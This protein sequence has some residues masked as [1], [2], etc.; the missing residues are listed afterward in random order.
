[1]TESPFGPPGST[2]GQTGSIADTHVYATFGT[3]TVTVTV[4]DNGGLSSTQTFQIV[5]GNVGPTV[6]PIAQQS[7]D[8]G[9]QFSLPGVTFNDP[10]TLD[11]H[12]ATVNWGDGSSTEVA[13]VTESPFGPPGSTSGLT[14]AIS[15]SHT[16]GEPGT[17]T[18]TISVTDNG[19]LTD[20]RTFTL[21]VNDVPPS[22]TTTIATGSLNEGSVLTTSTIGFS[23]PTF[24]VPALNY[25]PTFTYSIN[26]GDGSAVQTGSAPVTQAGSV[27]VATQGSF[28]LTHL[29]GV[30][31]TYT[32]TITIIDPQGGSSQ[33]SF[34]V[35]VHDVTP[36]LSLT[37]FTELD[38][39]S[40]TMSTGQTFDPGTNPLTV[41]VSWGDGTS[42]VFTVPGANLNNLNL[43]HIYLSPPDP[44]DPAAPIPVGVT[45]SQI[46]GSAVTQHFEVQVPG[47]GVAIVTFLP[48]PQ[49]PPIP[50]PLTVLTETSSFYTAPPPPISTPV[51]LTPARGETV[52]VA[53][54][55][56]VLRPVFP[57]GREGENVLLPPNVLDNLPGYL[58]RLPDGHY[59]VYYVQGDTHRERL[60]IDVNVRQGRPVDAGDDSEGT[61]DRPPS[62]RVEPP[63]GA[64]GPAI[65]GLDLP[66]SP[67]AP[68]IGAAGAAGPT[69]TQPAADR[70]TVDQG[71]QVLPEA[72][73][74]GPDVA[75]DAEYSSSRALN[76][77][78]ALAALAWASSRRQAARQAVPGGSEQ[79][80]PLGR[81]QSKAARLLRRLRHEFAAQGES[82]E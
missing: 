77:H 69:E 66:A 63:V 3:Y 81:R 14:G 52:G 72:A 48:E 23:D 12:T 80:P 46:V 22:F 42:T 39:L 21:V 8:E 6:Q 43:S 30:T 27:G 34:Q 38:V 28:A 36:T 53:E 57:T 13:T 82:A 68:A 50:P 26:W 16:Y 75:R 32:A 79:L 11:T 70:P 29:Y 31:G 60:I 7:V 45:I 58:K 74:P 40:M 18:V 19:G 41:T 10:G 73:L 17:Y 44:L 20:V 54:D 71:V 24:A 49:A 9:S 15:G 1:M 51:D 33:Q 61:Q 25:T 76:G 67:S 5:V 37:P 2:S 4:T 59:R 56:I 65:V 55:Q 62:A 35:V 78:V 47:T 64:T